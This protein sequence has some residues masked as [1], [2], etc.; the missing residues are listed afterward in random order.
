MSNNYIYET[1]V[2]LEGNTKN[3]YKIFN[4][5]LNV[6]LK[7]ENDTSSNNKLSIELDCG[8]FAI[9]N[10]KNIEDIRSIME[11]VSKKFY[12][13]SWNWLVEVDGEEIEEQ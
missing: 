7:N 9:I 10:F 2:T 12:K 13:E 6:S 4:T 5:L 1:T 3:S 8:N 11:K